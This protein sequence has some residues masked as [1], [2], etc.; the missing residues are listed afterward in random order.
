MPPVTWKNIAPVDNSGALDAFLKAGESIG[1]N[2]GGIGESITGY[3]DTQQEDTKNK[4]MMEMLQTQGDAAAQQN[5]I[6][7]YAQSN[8]APD[9][10]DLIDMQN[11]LSDRNLATKKLA[12]Q[13]E[14]LTHQRESSL[15]DRALKEDQLKHQQKVFSQEIAEYN[16]QANIRAFNKNFYDQMISTGQGA[17]PSNLN[18]AQVNLLNPDVQ[19]L[20]K[21]QI[22]SNLVQQLI[23]QTDPEKMEQIDTQQDILKVFKKYEKKLNQNNV[24]VQEQEKILR[25]VASHFGTTVP[26]SQEKAY[27][28][29]TT[30]TIK[31]VQA[32]LDLS[33]GPIPARSLNRLSTQLAGIDPNRLTAVHDSMANHVIRGLGDINIS[34]V[35]GG[36][37]SSLQTT[38]EGLRKMDYG[39]MTREDIVEQQQDMH[40]FGQ[41]LN[42]LLDTVIP[43][44]SSATKKH[45]YE[46]IR[47]RLDLDKFESKLAKRKKEIQVAESFKQSTKFNKLATTDVHA[48]V[49]DE[50][51]GGV[52][53]IQMADQVSAFLDSALAA[54]KGNKGEDALNPH[55]LRQIA[56]KVFG[57]IMTAD[58]EIEKADDW[59]LGDGGWVDDTELEYTT[60]DDGRISVKISEPGNA[61]IYRKF[62][63]ELKK[64]TGM[65]KNA[66]SDFMKGKVQ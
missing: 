63:R 53:P 28:A 54:Y 49:A 66:R 48:L 10:T 18:H 56:L 61:T 25:Q 1:K 27:Q 7:R 19:P 24:P 60:D 40:A 44:V 58:V 14:Q 5:I 37:A 45:M 41:R 16:D 36:N 17:S 34:D 13:N 20:A 43:N 11:S 35:K 55:T 59:I 2:I 29:D 22:N 21:Q 8:F 65:F 33:E 39:K 51:Y 64:A 31:N 15:L 38:V 26:A 12:F 30:R 23:S 46:N 3:A 32:Q 6:N 9:A 50:N 57:N 47:T 62:K 52:E 42:M 4:M